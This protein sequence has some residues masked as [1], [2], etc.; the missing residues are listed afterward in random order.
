[1]Q[2]KTV[3]CPIDGSDPKLTEAAVEQAAYICKLS[4]AKL[5]LLGV[6]E[7]WY[8]STHLVTDSSEWKAIHDEWMK[9]G[10]ETLRKA[11]DGLKAKG[12]KTIDIEVRDGDAAHEIVAAAMEA[13]ADLIIMTTHRHSAM[14][15]LFLGSVTDRVSK[16]APC[17]VL[18]VFA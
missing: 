14:G 5:I 6:V 2:Y 16:H 7:K 15:K 4:G 3:V 1:M 17:P 10:E 12:V 18:W 11:A 8:R 13:R 9:D